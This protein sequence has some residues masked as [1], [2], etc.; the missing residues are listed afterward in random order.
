MRKELKNLADELEEVEAINS[1]KAS[2]QHMIP[3]IVW[4]TFTKCVMPDG[5]IKVQ[6]EVRR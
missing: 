2:I 4:Q 6:F 1:M 5:T 3:Y